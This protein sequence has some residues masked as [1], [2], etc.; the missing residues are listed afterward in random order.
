MEDKRRIA[1]PS[2]YKDVEFKQPFA[3]C[4]VDF[5]VGYDG[6]RGMFLLH[7][8]APENIVIESFFLRGRPTRTEDLQHTREL[9]RSLCAMDSDELEAFLVARD[10]TKF[11]PFWFR[12][13]CETSRLADH[14]LRRKYGAK[15]F[16]GHDGC[17]P[18]KQRST[19]HEFEK[20]LVAHTCKDPRFSRHFYTPLVCGALDEGIS[21]KAIET[22]D[23]SF[24]RHT[25]KNQIR[26][27]LSR[28]EEARAHK[29]G[30]LACALGKIAE[31]YIHHF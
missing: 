12:R 18:S 20:F 19:V 29:P 4:G 24:L 22:L 23:Q 3:V 17:T 21:R 28:M 25:R 8:S 2:R 27:A 15:N 10:E 6:K 16:S 13:R 31:T 5:Y 30:E 14:N 7:T 11:N 9:A 26:K 1:I